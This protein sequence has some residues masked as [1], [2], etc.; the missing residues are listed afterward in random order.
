MLCFPF[1]TFGPSSVPNFTLIGYYVRTRKHD[2]DNDDD[3]YDD[4]NAADWNVKDLH[5]SRRKAASVRRQ[6]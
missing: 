4:D 1:G 2:N 5:T 3:D 6:R